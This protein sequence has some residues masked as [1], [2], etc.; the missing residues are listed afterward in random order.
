MIVSKMANY[1][2]IDTRADI[3]SC[4]HRHHPR[5]YFDD[6]LEGSDVIA[7]IIGE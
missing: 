2:V 7:G 4:C 5:L 1:Y 3:E 6:V